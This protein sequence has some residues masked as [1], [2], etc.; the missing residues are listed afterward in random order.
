MCVRECDSSQY[1][2][3]PVCAGWRRWRWRG[4]AS[5]AMNKKKKNIS[6]CHQLHLL[7][8][9]LSPCPLCS[10]RTPRLREGDAIKRGFHRHRLTGLIPTLTHRH[11]E[12]LSS[13]TLTDARTA[14]TTTTAV[15]TAT[16]NI[17]FNATAALTNATSITAGTKTNN[18]SISTTTALN[19]RKTAATTPTATETISA[20]AGTFTE[21]PLPL[22]LLLLLPLLGYYCCN[23]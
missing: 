19:I 17:N 16:A 1:W 3:S 8:S 6:L 9:P 7:S 15:S 10:S 21:F 23:Y 2:F 5:A 14:A 13:N 12:R 22:P 11:C 4:R 20:T 18:T